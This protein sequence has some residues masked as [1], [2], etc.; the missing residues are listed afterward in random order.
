[1]A[2][3]PY[4]R[5]RSTLRLAFGHLLPLAAIRGAIREKVEALGRA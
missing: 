1:M 3:R 4:L 2:L 5:E